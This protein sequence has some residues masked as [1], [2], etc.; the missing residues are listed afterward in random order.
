MIYGY[1]TV[2]LKTVQASELPAEIPTEPGT[3]FQ[4]GIKLAHLLFIPFF[5]LGKRW[6][7][8]KDGDSYEITPEAEE[9]FAALYGTP[10]TP[11]YAFSGLILIALFFLYSTVDDMLTSRRAKAYLDEMKKEKQ[12]EKLRGLKN[13]LVTDFYA[14]KSANGKYYGAK[15]DSVASGKV[16]LRCVANDQGY[17]IQTAD[18]IISKYVLERGEFFTYAVPKE[19]LLKSYQ[20]KKALLKINGLANQQALTLVEVY[21][22]DLDDNTTQLSIRDLQVEEEV[23][24][25]LRQFINTN[26]I[27]SSLMRMDSNSKKYFADVIKFANQKDVPQIKQFIKSSAYPSVTY[28][29][30]MYM[31]YG[32]AKS[33][34]K[35]PTTSLMNDVKIFSLFSKMLG[36]GL[37]SMSDKIKQY[38][39][40]STTLIRKNTASIRLSLNS[41]I[42]ERTSVIPFKVLF[43]YEDG[44]WKI[45]I[46]STFSYT[47][48]QVAKVGSYGSGPGM[49]R[50]K[51]RQELKEIDPKISFATE[52]MY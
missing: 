42:L 19:D 20:G 12:D 38:R 30:V 31:K 47:E 35:R 34:E 40:S 18:N 44:Q 3:S 41:N 26:S 21:N 46:P 52:L 29:L 32:Y 5:P 6:L 37:W 24:Q 36:M 22:R 45:N 28:A 16:W 49:F 43:K 48:N 9:L 2:S 51:V 14:L 15:V 13:P 25:A 8:K 7:M 1:Y 23:K 39:A 17:S 4:Y 11:W 33:Q 50:Q 27:D 10:K